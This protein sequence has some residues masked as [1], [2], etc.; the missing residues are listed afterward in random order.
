MGKDGKEERSREADVADVRS[1]HSPIEGNLP[2]GV[3]F[4]Q[5]DQNVQSAVLLDNFQPSGDQSLPLQTP[6]D[7]AVREAISSSLADADAIACYGTRFEI[8]HVIWF[9]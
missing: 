6:H 1:A 4:E 8:C 7:S 2:D 9:E 3:G 5:S